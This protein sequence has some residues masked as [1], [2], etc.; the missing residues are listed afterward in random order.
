MQQ[1]NNINPA[2]RDFDQ[3]PDSAQVRLPVPKALLGV[4]SATIWR[5]V[6]A[7]QLKSYKHH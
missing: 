3:L 6:K 5:M 4:S 1:S 2:L 7:K